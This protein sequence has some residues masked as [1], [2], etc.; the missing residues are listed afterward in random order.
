[1]NNRTRMAHRYYKEGGSFISGQPLPKNDDGTVKDKDFVN[2]S[3][4]C[5]CKHVRFIN[6]TFHSCTG[7]R[8]LR[9]IQH[10]VLV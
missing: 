7:H 9:I 2:C 4:H 1:M 10:G 6:C 8:N 5:N 3:F